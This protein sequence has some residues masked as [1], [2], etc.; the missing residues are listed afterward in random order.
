MSNSARNVLVLPPINIAKMEDSEAAS[1]SFASES[2]SDAPVQQ[3]TKFKRKYNKRKLVQDPT[4]YDL[5]AGMF[6]QVTSSNL[7]LN[8]ITRAN[9]ETGWSETTSWTWNK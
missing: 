3:K 2:S 1:P 9:K 6:D 4:I 8:I 7:L 5:I